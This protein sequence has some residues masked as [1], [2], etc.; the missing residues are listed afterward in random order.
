MH[1]VS[2][3]IGMLILFIGLSGCS[4]KPDKMAEELEIAV[5]NAVTEKL[6]QDTRSLVNQVKSR[7]LASAIV[8]G[9]PTGNLAP[10]QIPCTLWA[11][12]VALDGFVR[13]GD[14]RAGFKEL[15]G[16]DSLF[17]KARKP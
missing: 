4:Y 9:A 5:L 6:K 14:Q 1:R 10:L 13:Q 17:N 8:S 11:W 12:D 2:L 3:L 16:S 7:L 15:A